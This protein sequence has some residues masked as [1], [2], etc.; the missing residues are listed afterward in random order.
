[1][2]NI[3]SRNM[4]TRHAIRFMS[5]GHAWKQGRKRRCASPSPVAPHAPTSLSAYT[6]PPATAA[7][8]TR[9]GTCHPIGQRR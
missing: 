6:A 3:G 2:E 8:L 5:S 1:M 4:L 9:P 7:S